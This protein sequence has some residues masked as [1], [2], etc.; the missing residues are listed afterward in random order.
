VRTCDAAVAVL[1]E[2]NNHAVMWG[3]EGLCHMIAERAQLR[4][5]GH[6]WKTSDRVLI[7]LARKH[8]GLIAGTTLC[9]NRRVR[10]FWLPERAP[11][12]AIEAVVG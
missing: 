10:I 12:W 11:R 7:N 2:T 6:A 8:D 1:R 5:V 4:T 3:D 9:H